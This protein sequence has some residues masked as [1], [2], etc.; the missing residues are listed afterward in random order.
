MT[1]STN[2]NPE[3]VKNPVEQMTS[4][5][6]EGIIGLFDMVIGERRNYYAKHPTTKPNLTDLPNIIN[7][8]ANKNAVISGGASLIP[9]P[10]G[11]LT[12][13][14]EI[15]SVTRNQLA[16]I[17]EIGLA[18]GQEKVI[19]KE[20]L[21][22]VLASATGASL[23][24]LIIVHGSKI[25][26][27]RASLRV[28]QQIVILLGGKLTQQVLKSSISRWIP[29]VGAAAMAAWSYQSTKLIAAKAIEVF[30]KEIEIEAEEIDTPESVNS[31]F[32]ETE[33]SAT[34]H[35]QNLK[36]SSLQSIKIQLLVN[37]MLSDG[38][39]SSDEQNHINDLVKGMIS[40]QSLTNEDEKLLLEYLKSPQHK[41]VDLTGFLN[42]PDD[43]M[44]LV[45]D[46]VALAK[47]DGEVRFAER[48]Y[49]ISVGKSVGFAD[50]DL[51]ELLTF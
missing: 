46:M 41:D 6:A 44:G 8:Y 40:D 45:V 34:S 42:S 30:R 50:T 29:F 32:G 28:F 33:T 2:L 15:I 4:S 10:L 13:V 22:A 21:A 26:V 5:I 9:G 38:N 49:I 12:V 11:M 7:D 39:A 18:H 37:L 25:I 16:M 47:R 3:T 51:E 48:A 31:T 14:P 1:A 17:Y 43:A 24:A 27:K 35:L 23:G 20:L 19:T 36:F